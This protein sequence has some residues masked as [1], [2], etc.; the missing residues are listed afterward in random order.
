MQIL[1]SLSSLR[2]LCQVSPFSFRVFGQRDH[3]ISLLVFPPHGYYLQWKPKDLI[4]KG[5]LCKGSCCLTQLLQ[6]TKEI[7]P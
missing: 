4:S 5:H 3:Q 2:Q 1:L 7:S 6:D